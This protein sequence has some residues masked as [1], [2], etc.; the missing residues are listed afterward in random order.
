M[1]P[2]LP[3]ELGS[4][5]DQVPVRDP[6]MRA[7]ATCDRRTVRGRCGWFRA[8]NLSVDVDVFVLG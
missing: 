1:R 2:M 6:E 4:D 3:R 8:R 7:Q 5:P